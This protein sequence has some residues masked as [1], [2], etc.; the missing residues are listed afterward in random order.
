[1]NKNKT[2]TPDFE[3]LLK[4]MNTGINKLI[5]INKNVGDVKLGVKNANAK[6]VNSNLGIKSLNIKLVSIDKNIGKLLSSFTDIPTKE[7][8]ENY[9][10]EQY[11]NESIRETKLTNDLLLDI[12][13]S[14]KFGIGKTPKKD[15][16]I[17]GILGMLG[18]SALFGMGKKGLG[19]G[20]KLLGL[21]VGGAAIGA[22]AGAA[23]T[24]LLGKGLKGLKFG[25]KLLG[26][27]LGMPIALALLGYGG[28]KGFSESEGNGQEKMLGAAKGALNNFILDDVKDFYNMLFDKNKI[29]NE[30]D[31][32]VKD[33]SGEFG[34]ILDFVKG[35]FENV[36]GNFSKDL[37]NLFVVPDWLKSE[38]WESLYTDPD[39]FM[40]SI[41]KGV[42]PIGM[43]QSG[44]GNVGSGSKMVAGV[45]KAASD[46]DKRAYMSY[47]EEVAKKE[48]IDPN[49]MKGLIQQES[50]WNPNAVSSAGAIGLTQ[51]LPTTVGDVGGHPEDLFDPYKNIQYG[52]RYLKTLL[53][54][55]NGDYNKALTAYH[56]GMENVDKG[57]IG[58]IGQV[59]ASQV[60]E[61]AGAFRELGP[62]GTGEPY[63]FAPEISLKGN[64]M[65]TP[66]LSPAEASLGV[67]SGVGGYIVDKAGEVGSDWWKTT[68]SDVKSG[69]N[70][71]GDKLGLN[72]RGQKIIKGTTEGQ[73]ARKWMAEKSNEII[74]YWKP[75]VV[76]I[77]EETVDFWKNYQGFLYENKTPPTPVQEPNR[78]K[79]MQNKAIEATIKDKT[80][81]VTPVVNNNNI[82]TN[83]AT[84]NQNYP[85]N[86]DSVFDWQYAKMFLNPNYNKV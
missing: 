79:N 7:K 47:A 14:L 45:K 80:T 46:T 74:D 83:N 59:Y 77:A 48:G 68:K 64:N 11:Q 12:R 28:I 66:T 42:N 58:P 67:M 39:K 69:I 40:E 19:L 18:I 84:Q 17:A 72:E 3:K 51:M 15:G 33:K 56:S 35:D 86:S 29:E 30:V 5:L 27:T 71:V 75:K 9:L 6:I 73:K 49:I 50:N 16:G 25:G 55:Y 85:I 57:N 54:R 31:K 41:E 37:K 24:G 81:T 61:K 21:G 22:G 2:E 26:K 32:Q 1:M 4:S 70:W 82:M 62:V 65:S 43:V 8:E 36:M 20:G 52:A 34:E 23:G 63:K 38:T 60:Q 44:I 10:S 76:P 13:D 78:T 53:N